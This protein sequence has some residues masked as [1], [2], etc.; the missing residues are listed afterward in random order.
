L[1]LS[2]GEFTGIGLG[3]LAGCTRPRELDLDR[4]PLSHTHLQEA[5][6]LGHLRRLF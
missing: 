5:V 1:S 6:I 2:G 4:S 3:Q